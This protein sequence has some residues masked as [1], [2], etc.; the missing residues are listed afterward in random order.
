MPEKKRKKTTSPKRFA[1]E[2]NL[3][4]TIKKTVENL[5][6]MSETD[7]GFELFV[8]TAAAG[9][10]TKEEILRQTGKSAD[11]P[12]EERNFDEMFERLM[13]IQDWFGDDE[14]KQA[15]NFKKLKALFENNLKDLKVFRIGQIQIDIYF[16]GL[17]ENNNLTGVKTFAVET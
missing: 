10:V 12:I 6:Y 3:L 4:Q 7:A 17:D 8:G 14:T 9:G 15:E 1:A 2:N 13:T 11:A 5:S 16:V